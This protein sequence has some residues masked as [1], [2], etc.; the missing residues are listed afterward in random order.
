MPSDLNSLIQK[1]QLVPHFWIISVYSLIRFPWVM[2]IPL[3][4]IWIPLNSDVLLLT[5]KRGIDHLGQYSFCFFFFCTFYQKFIFILFELRMH[6][7]L[8][9]SWRR[10]LWRCCHMLTLLWCSGDVATP[11]NTGT[12]TS[13]WQSNDCSQQNPNISEQLGA[14]TLLLFN[15]LFCW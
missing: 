9:S 12:F 6:T 2:Q 8:T 3:S 15:G 11:M 13:S 10:C 4:P 14:R 5:Q 1:S 7:H